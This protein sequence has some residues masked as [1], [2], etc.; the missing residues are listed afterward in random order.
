ML[1]RII[2]RII[3]AFFTIFLSAS[4]TF[5]LIYNIP[6]SVVDI[7]AAQLAEE[8]GVPFEEAK[9]IALTYYV[10]YDPNK[11]LLER[12]VE[13]ILNLLTGNLGR[14][15]I[16]RVPVTEVI[17]KALPWTLFVLSTALL[18]SFAIGV[19]LG[20]IIA[21]RRRTIL[22][23]IVT[24]YASFTD[25]MP[26]FVTAMILYIVL[27]VRLKLFPMKGAYSESLTPG[28][29]PDFILSVLYHA[30]LPIL[31]YVVEHV[32]FWALLMKGSAASVLEEDFVK[33]AVA[34]GLPERRILTAY[35]GRVAIL[36][37]AVMLA[38]QL[39]A[40]LGGSTII[41]TVFNYPG[42]GYF[43]AYATQN[44][45]YGLMQGL[46][47]V[48][49]VGIVVANLVIDIIYPLID[50]RVRREAGRL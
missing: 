36:P 24:A 34:R 5:F 2:K 22:G 47:F 26:D 19:L 6:G 41:E 42:I 11:P 18:T 30:T 39:G 40:M 33:A 50:P 15:T 43:F 27:A 17:V 25:A 16:F 28:L 1:W 29:Y 14:S 9:E 45:D 38:I 7:I 35:V 10:G 3:Y 13:Y 48:I 44:L 8:M 20:L 21:W 32:G 46:F 12:Y 37:V 23:P 49:I 31:A 4:I